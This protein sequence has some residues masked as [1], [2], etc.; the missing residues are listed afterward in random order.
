VSLAADRPKIFDDTAA[1]LDD[2]ASRALDHGCLEHARLGYQLMGFLRWEGGNWTDARRQMLQAELVSRSAD[3][4]GRVLGMSEA[5]RCLAML[6]RDLPE[7][8]AMLLE[9]EA[10][11]SRAGIEPAAIPDGRGM[12]RLHQGQLDEAAALFERA[13]LI[14]R[15]DGDRRAEFMAL[16]HL[17]AV[18]LQRADYAKASGLCR[19]LM[20]LGEKLRE[21]SEAPFAQALCALSRYAT[22]E[23]S[24]R[25]MLDRA[26]ADLRAVDAKQR[27]AFVLVRAA[28]VEL[29]RGDADAAAPLAEE[30][31]TAAGALGR[32]SDVALAHAMAGRVAQ[33]A[34]DS[35]TFERHVRALEQMPRES[36]SAQARRAVDEV[37][38]TA[39]TAD[40]DKPAKRSRHDLRRR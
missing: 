38:D 28:L 35:A 18:E 40:T 10:I 34:L 22:G 25:E 5:A 9:A 39:A 21:G 30:A 37:L 2:L 15:R 12:L 36:L 8:E 14:A 32:P 26:L 29:E 24:A 20:A 31:V 7:A 1:L 16:E 19:E 27:L 33:A 17:I 23:R 11:A 6:E 13:R 4:R 3:A